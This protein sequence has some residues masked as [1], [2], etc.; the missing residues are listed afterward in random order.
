MFLKLKKVRIAAPLVLGLLLL[1]TP[2]TTKAGSIIDIGAGIY[3]LV[4]K[5]F[6]GIGWIISTIAGVAIVLEAWILGFVLEINSHIINSPPVQVGFPVALSI[7]NLALVLAIVIIAIMTILRIQTYGVKQTLWKLI[8]I[9]VAINFGLIAA[10]VILQF[11]DSLS[12]YFLSA[13]N[14]VG[15]QGGST[16]ADFASALA[17]AFNPQRTV[18]AGNADAGLIAN[19][20]AQ[21]S[22]AGEGIGALLTPITATLFT[23]FALIFIIV[24]LGALIVMLIIRYVY[25]GFLLILLPL[26][27]ASWIFPVTKGHWNKWW[28]NFFNQAA[29][30]PIVLFFLW[31]A[32]QTSYALYGG[33]AFSF[34]DAYTTPTDG[35]VFAA[36]SGFFGKLFAPVIAQLLNMAVL[37]GVMIGGLFVAKSMS[38]KFADAAL[39]AASGSAATF[40]KWA[41][42]KGAQIGTSP[43]RG[44][45]GQKVTTGLQQGRVQ[46]AL[47]RV[48]GIGKAMGL[49]ASYLGGG[50]ERLG[51]AGADQAVKSAGE[52]ISKMTNQQV[53]NGMSRFDA[54]TRWAALQK[55]QKDGDLGLVRNLDRYLGNENEAKRYNLGEFYKQARGESG[56]ALRDYVR[57]LD[58]AKKTGDQTTINKAQDELSK[59]LRAAGKTGQLAK[60]FFKDFKD[61]KVAEKGMP[62]DMDVSEA[63]RLQEYIAKGIMEDFT[64]NN[65]SGFVQE[66]TRGDQ[67]DILKAAG[68]RSLRNGVASG[69]KVS[70]RFTKYVNSSAAR[71]AGIDGTTFGLTGDITDQSSGGQPRIIIPPG[72]GGPRN[73]R[74]TT[75]FDEQGNPIT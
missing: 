18:V 34:G 21:V 16:Y 29:F 27:W 74:S 37:L 73:V 45:A 70:S 53:A 57:D 42:R 39:G 75:R 31:V 25:L 12:F 58:N 64:G 43:L 28:H 56:L 9:A 30:A 5:V 54:P 23:I 65:I 4:G 32:I 13:I 3:G 22:S 33:A 38:I 71:S 1:L 46:Q 19:Y 47:R 72:A 52:N 14:P 60:T 35:S 6:F 20:Q 41:G 48:P 61:P 17:G 15:G 68:E 51:V 26:A 36:I 24:T 7:A 44:K 63:E 50:I 11:F 2:E 69:N 8:V 49:G 55:L 67:L 62:L 40:G 59:H 66:A 10:G